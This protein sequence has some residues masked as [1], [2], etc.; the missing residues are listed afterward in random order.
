MSDNVTPKV[1]LAFKKIFGVEENKDLLISLINAIVY[2]EDRAESIEIMNPYNLQSFKK[3][4]LSILDIKAKRED[5]LKYNIEI[6]ISDEGDYDKRAL[7]YWAKAYTAQLENADQYVEL[8]KTIGIHILN[9]LSI[10]HTKEYH[11]VFTPQTPGGKISYFKDFEMHTIEL[12]KFGGKNIEFEDLLKKVK[13]PLD[14]WLTFLTQHQ[15]MNTNHMP[16]ELHLPEIGKAM[17]V[18]DGMNLNK[19]ER[20]IYNNRLK[21]LRIEASTL[22]KRYTE[23][24]AEGKA[25]GLAEGKIEGLAEGE[26]KGLAEGEAKGLAEGEAKGKAEGEAKG[27]AEGEINAK[28]EI[29]KKMLSKN[30]DIELISDI[31]GLSI[32][33]IKE[34]Q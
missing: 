15:Y 34:I 3:D 10:P 5:G 29:A 25:E 6:Q 23:G 18:L 14:E 30:Q 1:D 12:C 13:I 26:A 24:K 22:Q 8:R 7:Y 27:L 4:K 33:K 16:K 19:E 11:N 28:R 20:E 17:H 2:K 32:E 31:T 9:F 21:W